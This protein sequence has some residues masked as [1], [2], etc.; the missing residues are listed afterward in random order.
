M[1]SRFVQ[2][3]LTA[4]DE[5]AVTARRHV[6]QGVNLVPQLSVTEVFEDNFVA[7]LKAREI[8]KK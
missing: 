3:C 8:I 4:E 7:F 5:D 1:T 2:D 6:P